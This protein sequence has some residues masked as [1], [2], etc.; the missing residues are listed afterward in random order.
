[1]SNSHTARKIAYGANANEC[2]RSHVLSVCLLVMLIF[3]VSPHCVS[4][5]LSFPLSLSSSLF[6]ASANSFPFSKYMHTQYSSIIFIPFHVSGKKTPP[7]V[8]A[9]KSNEFSTIIRGRRPKLEIQRKFTEVFWF[10]RGTPIVYQI[11]RW[12]HPHRIIVIRICTTLR[13]TL[14]RN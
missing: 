4:A 8:I 11:I 5:I 10:A 9:S 14:R 13:K 7:F 12:P 6:F 2:M 1:M 3:L